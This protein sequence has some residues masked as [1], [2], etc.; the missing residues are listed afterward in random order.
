M[1][2]KHLVTIAAVTIVLAVLGVL[3]FP[4]DSGSKEPEYKGQKLRKWVA[5]QYTARTSDEVRESS[6][7][8]QAIGSNAI[9]FLLKWMDDQPQPRSWKQKLFIKPMSS[10]ERG[11]LSFGS[12]LGLTRLKPPAA[13]VT[14][15]I[16]QMLIQPKSTVECRRNAA[17]ALASIDSNRQEIVPIFLSAMCSSNGEVREAAGA[18]LNQYAYAIAIDPIRLSTL[19]VLVSS[20]WDTNP[21][22]VSCSLST[23]CLFRIDAEN[24]RPA[25]TN[26]L[27]HPSEDVRMR[28]HRAFE[29]IEGIK[30]P[31]TNAP[32]P[33][34]VEKL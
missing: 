9:P 8:L 16:F 3:A 1:R 7:A 21:K 24:L 34:L 11:T 17:M 31:D 19:P 2:R 15:Q 32:G 13:A 18:G 23:L 5:L 28:T 12:Y 30:F 29:W 26:L 6:A 27:S 25:L 33:R 14:N 10:S 4:H 20:L 22:I